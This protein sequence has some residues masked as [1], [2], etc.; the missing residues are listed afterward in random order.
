[1]RLQRLDLVLEAGDSLQLPLAALGSGDAVAHA[2]ALGLDA[3]LTLHVDGRERRRFPRHLGHSLRLLFERLQAR[4]LH[5]HGVLLL[6]LLL[7]WHRRGRVAAHSRIGA[8]EARCRGDRRVKRAQVG[9]YRWFRAHGRAVHGSARNRRHGRHGVVDGSLRGRSDAAGRHVLVVELG[10]RAHEA[11]GETFLLVRDIFRT[12]E[13]GWR[14]SRGDQT[15]A[16]LN[17]K[18]LELWRGQLE[19]ADVRRR[20]NVIYFGAQVRLE[21]AARVRQVQGHAVLQRLG[22]VS[23]RGAVVLRERAAQRVVVES[24]FHLSRHRKTNQKLLAQA[25]VSLTLPIHPS[26][27]SACF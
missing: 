17:N 12:Q 10:Q 13:L 5:G 26:L 3:L 1:M 21:R 23:E 19:E 22:V 7:W 4:V 20:E 8:G 14:G 16:G 11:L 6:L 9:V 24:S 27:L 25:V 15:V 18:A 2:L